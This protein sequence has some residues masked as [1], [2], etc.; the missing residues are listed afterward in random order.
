MK[1]LV[2]CETSCA[3]TYVGKQQTKQPQC[4]QVTTDAPQGSLTARLARPLFQQETTITATK[5]QLQQQFQK[6]L[7]K[8]QKCLQKI[9]KLLNKREIHDKT[10]TTHRNN[11]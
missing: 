3:T 7:S 1:M 6:L 10:E 11:C 2:L 5:Q 4:K 9:Q 8:C